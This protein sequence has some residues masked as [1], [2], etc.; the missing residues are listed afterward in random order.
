MA[1]IYI[2]NIQDA[3]LLGAFLDESRDALDA[4]LARETTWDADERLVMVDH[5]IE[6]FQSVTD[7]ED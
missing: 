4:F 7:D 3:E 1:V 5:F 2:D 6:E